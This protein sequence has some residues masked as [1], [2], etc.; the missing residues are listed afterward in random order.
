MSKYE[1]KRRDRVY[2]K[3][4]YTGEK[5]E[6][7]RQKRK[8]LYKSEEAKAKYREKLRAEGKQSKKE[9]L[10]ELRQKIKA[11][12]QQGFKNIEIAQELSLPSKTLERH[13]TYMRKNGLL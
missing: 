4:T 8:E 3:A 13:I 11:M 6:Y 12:R 9:Q 5:A 2:Q 1:Y 10:N 7:K